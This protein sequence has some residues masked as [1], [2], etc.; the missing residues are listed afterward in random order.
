MASKNLTGINRP[1]L[2][3]VANTQHL[4]PHASDSTLQAGHGPVGAVKGEGGHVGEKKK[5]AEKAQAKQAMPQATAPVSPQ[6]E[7]GGAPMGGTA[8]G[9]ASVVQEIKNSFKGKTKRG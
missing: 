3:G 4:G 6:V 7:E 2:A 8:G 1:T 9:V 5:F